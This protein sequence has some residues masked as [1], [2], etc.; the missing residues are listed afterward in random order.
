MKPIEQIRILVVGDIMLDKYVVGDTDRISPEAPVAIVNVTNEYYTLGG[1]GNVIRNIAELGAK[2]DCL[3][4]IAMDGDG[5][6]VAAELGKI[7]ARPLLFYGSKTTTVKERIIAN[8]RKT[9]ML[10]VDRECIQ[11][12]DTKLA[13]DLFK[14]KCRNVYDMV[15]VSDYAKGM[16]T[17][18]LME[19]LKHD[20]DADIIV[21]PKPSN[22]TLYD[23]VFMITPNDKEWGQMCLSSSNTLSNVPYIVKTKG[24]KGMDVIVNNKSGRNWTIEAEDVPVYNVSGAGDVVVAMMAICLSHGLDVLDSAYISNKCAGYAV[25]QPQTC[26]VPK[27]KFEEIYNNY[28]IPNNQ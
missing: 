28:V 18:E 27:N 1:C 6:L 16:I 22:M 14:E 8:N 20:Q 17:Q 21:D 12:I 19:F 10:R 11:I 7:G 13:I 25:T 26:V 3:S 2:V 9:Q 15:V 5:V 4:S 24:N 23:G